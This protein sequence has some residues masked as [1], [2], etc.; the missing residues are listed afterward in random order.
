MQNE[1]RDAIIENGLLTRGDRCII[2]VS[3]GADSMGL[4]HVLVRLNG[5]FKVNYRVVHVHHGLRGAEADRDANFVKNACLRYN[6]P[7]R[8]IRVNVLDFAQ[9][10]KLSIEEAARYLRYQALEN[11]AVQWETEA[12]TEKQV[13]IAVAH[14][15]E[16]NAETILMQ[17][18][19]GSGLRGLSGMQYVRKRIIRPL[20]DIPREE[21]EK[22][23][24]K[25][26]ESWINDSTNAETEYTRNRIRH[27]ILPLIISEVNNGAV[28]NI[29]RAGKLVGQADSY[30]NS[31]A[32]KILEENVYEEDSAYCFPLDILKKQVPII[33]S[34]IVKL[35]LAKINKT[36][37]NITSKNIDDITGL[38]D[39]ET[40]KRIDLP[41]RLAA[42]RDYESIKVYRRELPSM[43]HADESEDNGHFEFTTF[44]Y[45]GQKAPE[46]KYTKWFDYDKIDEPME[47]RFRQ[48]GDYFKLKGVGKKS[49]RTYMTDA[50]IPNDIRDEIPVIAAGNHVM[51]LVGYRIS[52][53]YKI[54]KSTKTIVEIKYIKETN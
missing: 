31:Q 52:E 26:D 53:A 44:D 42:E 22:Y 15:R 38:I 40:G 4:L 51:W 41:Y 29:T 39:S 47:I 11:E 36:M 48:A 32:S 3:G 35:L 7:C 45:K 33:Q 24:V 6:I 1:V 21:I 23:L 49:L 5:I 25:E 8:I 50:K 20:L 30:I 28:E 2:A 13:K 43:D 34:Y 37:K 9:S 27:D 19:R 46:E 18:A 12:D 17:A 54:D 10:R 14:N 16:D